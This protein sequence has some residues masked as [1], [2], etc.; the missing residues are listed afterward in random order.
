VGQLVVAPRT[1]GEALPSKDLQLLE[2]IALQAGAV[3]HA[4][5][6]TA[7]L[8]RSRQRLVTAREEERRRLRR[9]LHDGLG[10]TLASHT[11]RLDTAM[12]MLYENPDA[13]VTQLRALYEQTQEIVV[14]MRQLIHQLWPPVLDELGLIGAVQAH[15]RRNLRQDSHSAIVA[16]ETTN[17]LTS[18]PAAVELAAY[19]IA[20]E[21]VTG[22]MAHPRVEPCQ[23]RFALITRLDDR[24][25]QIHISNNGQG[26]PRSLFEGFDLTL[27]RERAEEIGG[28]LVVE[29]VQ[30]GG[31]RLLA[32]LPIVEESLN[33]SVNGV[34][35]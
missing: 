19:Y 10:P 4:V 35:E 28:H 20:I 6:L 13:V 3:A 12:G 11:L 32:E 33:V 8:Q 27:I 14:S 34:I 25:L 7:A 29:A 5:R 24:M 22:V 30:G 23:I 2:D 17:G 26:V 31:Q 16:V 1:P 18:L 15:I 21:A 9:D